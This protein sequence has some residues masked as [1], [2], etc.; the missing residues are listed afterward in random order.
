MMFQ[1]DSQ[2]KDKNIFFTL[3][4]LVIV[5][6]SCVLSLTDYHSLS[7]EIYDEREMHMMKR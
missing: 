4:M 5:V 2:F 1:F 6:N 3:V 7:K